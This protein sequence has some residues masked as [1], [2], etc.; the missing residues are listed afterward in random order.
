M[1]KAPKVSA[2]LCVCL[3]SLMTSLSGQD[4]APTVEQCRADQRLWSSAMQDDA[5]FA[6]VVSKLSAEILAQRMSQ[7]RDC[8]AVD[9]ENSRDYFVVNAGYG[10]ELGTR[11][12]DFIARHRLMTQFVTEDAVGKR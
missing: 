12:K 11:Y 9:G 8:F 5:T 4:H 2:A 10:T 1:R 7:M 3:L 6:K